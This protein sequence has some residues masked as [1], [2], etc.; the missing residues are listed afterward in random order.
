MRILHII[1]GHH[2]NGAATYCKLLCERLVQAGHQPF[3]MMRSGC[4]LR[5]VLPES[6]PVVECEMKRSVQELRSASAWVKSNQIDVIHT[7]MTKAH[8]FGV[9][10]KKLAGIPVIATAHNRS[11][12]LHW[13]FNDYVIANSEATRNYHRRRNFIAAGKIETV[14][15]YSDLTPYES[16][17]D[18]QTDKVRR[19]LNLRSDQIVAGIVG[20]VHRRK[21]QHDLVSAL[22]QIVEAIPNFRL[23]VV[24]PFGERGA[25]SGQLHSTLADQGLTDRVQWLGVRSDIPALMSVFDLLTVPSLEEPLG[26]VA[27]E[28]LAAGTPVV[29]TNV[30]GLPEIVQHEVNGLLVSPRKPLQL[31]DAIIRLAEHAGLRNRLGKAGRQMVSETFDPARLTQRVEQIY[32]EVAGRLSA[33]KRAA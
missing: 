16:I 10:L 18:D 8:S 17:T 12:E 2:I 23:V 33:G 25:Y 7:H 29:A 3:I 9:L 4:W 26:L 19:E 24:G 28:A 15:C 21:G 6:I 13:R 11:F 27:I 30:G 5:D 14:Y 22:P 1:S 31:A 20:S 32:D